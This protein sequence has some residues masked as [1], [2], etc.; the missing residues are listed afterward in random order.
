MRTPDELIVILDAAIIW[1]AG[2]QNL[3]LVSRTQTRGK[4]SHRVY[5]VQNCESLVV[6]DSLDITFVRV[7]FEQQLDNSA[8]NDVVL[9]EAFL[10]LGVWGAAEAIQGL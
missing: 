2:I 10:D 1:E 7:D 5:Q 8:N 9:F 6:G 4:P 3:D